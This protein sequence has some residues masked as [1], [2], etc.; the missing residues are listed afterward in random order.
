MD[1]ALKVFESLL[2]VTGYTIISAGAM[3]KIVP[4]R[5]AVKSAVDIST[6]NT[7]YEKEDI[8]VT[9]LIPLKYAEANQVRTLL[10][11]LISKGGNILGY[12]PTNTIIITEL[13]ANI[14]RLIKIIRSLSV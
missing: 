5:E 7:L 10:A 13:K 2:E 12:A 9:Q 3:N 4:T 6:G 14:C 8:V 11:P 1:E